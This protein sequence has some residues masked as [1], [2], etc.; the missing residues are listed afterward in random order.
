MNKMFKLFFVIAV[1]FSYK[2]SVD[3]KELVLSYAPFYYERSEEGGEY[4]SWKFPKYDIDGETAYCI[5]FEIQQGTTYEEV[6]WQ[7][8]GIDESKKERLL[9]IA[10]YGYDYKGHDNDYYR[11]ATQGLLWELTAHNNAT[12]N[13]TTERYG[14]GDLVDVSREREEIENLVLHHYDKPDFKTNYQVNLDEK[15]E[16][17][18][19]L[20]K[21]YDIVDN[22]GLKVEKS[23]HRLVIEPDKVG[24]Y[25][26]K[27][28]KKQVYHHD[29][30]FLASTGYQNMVSAGNVPNVDFDI[31]IEVLGGKIKLEKK[32]FDTKE[33]ILKE[34]I[35][36]KI[37]NLDNNEDVCFNSTCTFE[38]DEKGS[39]TTNELKYGTYEI[40]EICE[41]IYGYQCN[42]EPIKVVLNEKTIINNVVFVNFYNK[43]SLG[44]VNI[45][46]ENE[47]NEPLNKI[48]F[49]LEALE[50]IK[51]NN[52]IIYKKGYVISRLITDEFGNASIDNLPLGKYLLY[53]VKTTEGYILDNT[54]YE[55]DLTYKDA[56]T[57]PTYEKTF[58]NYEEGEGNTLVPEI[59]GEEVVIP[60]VIEIDVPDTMSLNYLYYL[61]NLYAFLKSR[62][63]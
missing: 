24:N 42:K 29:Y 7:E 37:K 13:F 4:K 33:N 34:G 32:D 58:I 60:P 41:N 43:R 5:Q 61:F 39:F 40:T 51:F 50:D 26:L 38:T 11:A 49:N 1:I 15:L 6:D 16:L 46:K 27:L 2:M 20:L 45:H 56:Y 35:K 21:D 30:H 3:A 36:F 12:V 48:E 22:N 10:Y 59:L 47:F 63:R 19:S 9:L 17:N 28:R 14:K 8:M 44:S 23:D 52:E 57:T 25:S 18:S 31:N 54:K 55:I 62:R 53:E